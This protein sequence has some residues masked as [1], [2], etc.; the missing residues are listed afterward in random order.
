[1][2]VDPATQTKRRPVWVLSLLGV[3]G[4]VVLF[5]VNRKR[6]IR[7]VYLPLPADAGTTAEA[8][9]FPTQTTT[10]EVEV[11]LRDPA[12]KE[13]FAD[14][15]RSTETSDFDVQ[16]SARE[17]D[18]DLANG[19]LTSYLYLSMTGPYRRRVRQVLGLETYRDVGTSRM[20]RGVGRF[21]ATAGNPIQ[22]KVATSTPFPPEVSSG[23]PHVVVRINRRTAASYL[24][25]SMALAS[26]L[27]VMTIL[28]IGVSIRFGIRRSKPRFL[29]APPGIGKQV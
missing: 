9:F 28:P 2:N 4:L 10:Y 8:T 26:L 6:D 15:I 19:S 3:V 21:K 24:N 27:F 18:K 5:V 17:G 22:I 14:Y 11:E 16:W 23:D 25:Q 29:S 7:P 1:M 12:Q 20:S 13:V